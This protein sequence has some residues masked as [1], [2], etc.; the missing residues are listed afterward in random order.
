M[1][2]MKT[3]L[4]KGSLDLTVFGA[5]TL[6][7]L[8]RAL[9]PILVGLGVAIGNLLIVVITRWFSRVRKKLGDLGDEVKDDLPVELHTHIDEIIKHG[10]KILTESEKHIIEEIKERIK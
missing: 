8:T 5:I 4:Y 3:I 10:D 2:H 7:D 6:S 1:T 9:N